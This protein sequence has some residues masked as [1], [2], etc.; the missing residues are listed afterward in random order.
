MAGA[1][2]RFTAEY[3]NIPPINMSTRRWMM[4]LHESLA[5]FFTGLAD[6][7]QE[8]LDESLPTYRALTRPD[9][10][11][12]AQ[13]D[14]VRTTSRIARLRTMAAYHRREFEVARNRILT[15]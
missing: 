15:A 6:M 13:L 11:L 14:R 12:N 9:E 7:D 3:I 10:L 8:Y 4:H 2:D 1:E 5:Q